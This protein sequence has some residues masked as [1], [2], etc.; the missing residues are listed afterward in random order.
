MSHYLF[1]LWLLYLLLFILPL[2]LSVLLLATG[3]V[4]APNTAALVA[5]GRPALAG[6][7]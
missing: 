2:P 5:H 4:D 6:K 7:T 3:V 1:W